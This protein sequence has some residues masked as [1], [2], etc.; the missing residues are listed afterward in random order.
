VR[1]YY[2]RE[3]E[4]R[5]RSW[6][7]RRRVWR[8]PYIGRRFHDIRRGY[9]VVRR[10]YKQRGYHNYCPDTPTT[11]SL[12]FELVYDGGLRY[13]E[14]GSRLCGNIAWED[15]SLPDET[16]MVYGIPREALR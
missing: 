9:G 10:V 12:V 7:E 3:R 14:D 16:M 13:I 4:G 6:A 2:G 1:K 15:G 11:W 5:G 8:H